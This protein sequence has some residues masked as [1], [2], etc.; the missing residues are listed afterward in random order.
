MAEK[1]KKGKYDIEL[2]V[3]GMSFDD[4]LKATVSGKKPPATFLFENNLFDKDK[5]VIQMTEPDVDF[6]K[7]PT[8]IKIQSSKSTIR[9]IYSEQYIDEQQYIQKVALQIPIPKGINTLE[10]VIEPVESYNILRLTVFAISNDE[11]SSV[12]ARLI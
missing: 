12:I 2:N 3:E 10:V 8:T 1:K 7:N 4:L 11:Q 6:E 9:T 5:I